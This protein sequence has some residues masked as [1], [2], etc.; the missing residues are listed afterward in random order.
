MATFTPPGIVNLVKDGKLRALAVTT[1]AR[2]PD[3]PDV[4][5]MREL[6]LDINVTNWN[7]FFA[8]AGTPK[9]IVDKLAT[10]LRHVVLNTEANGKLRGMFTNPVGKTP[11]DTV[12]HIETDM[13]VWKDV[14]AAAN[15]KFAN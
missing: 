13:K 6:G 8:P 1:A 7:G 14:I 15:L 5:T 4:P 2:S 10:A 3:L 9:P 11:D 12:R